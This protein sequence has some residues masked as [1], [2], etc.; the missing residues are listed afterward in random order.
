[1]KLLF[2]L[3]L[4]FLSACATRFIVPGNRFLT[5]ESQ[6]G[7][8]NGQLEMQSGSAN[9]LVVN[10][11]E[12]NTDK[13]V[14]Y[15]SI[16]R[17]GFLAST[18]LLDELDLFWSHTGAANSMLGAKFQFLGGNRLT[19]EVG[20]KMA[21]ALAM[22]GNEHITEGADEIQ[23][24]LSGQEFMFLYGYRFSENVMPYLNVSKST[25]HLDGRVVSGP[26]GGLTPKF[27]TDLLAGYL[28]LE[29]S[30][31]A[32]FTK[33]ECGYQYITTTDT[34]PFSGIHFGY[35]LGFSW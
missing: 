17:T 2:L 32:V 12:G 34:T 10:T 31:R 35:S 21:L 5:P 9:Q 30:Y 15:G 24:T 14:I 29:L 3:A 26:Q 28:G 16:A 8:F 18:S 33:V 22:G 19:K 6:G 20:H 1:M 23:F 4:F 11:S 13:G 27:K 25:Y 7:V